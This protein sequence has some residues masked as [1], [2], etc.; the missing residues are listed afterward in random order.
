MAMASP[1][2]ITRLGLEVERVLGIR[3]LLPTPSL[4]PFAKIIAIHPGESKSPFEEICKLDWVKGKHRSG[5]KEMKII[6]TINLN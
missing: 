1:P 6:G 4:R 2:L 5:E 3:Q